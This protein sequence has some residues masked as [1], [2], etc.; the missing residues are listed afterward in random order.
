M[1]QFLGDRGKNLTSAGRRALVPRLAGS[2]REAWVRRPASGSLVTVWA[3]LSQRI[4]WMRISFVLC[5][6]VPTLLTALY[7]MLIAPREYTTE[8]KFAVRSAES[9]PYMSASGRTK[10]SG[11]GNIMSA[12]RD[13]SQ[14]QEPF[15]VANYIR[16]RTIIE[17][18]GGRALLYEIYSRP[19]IGGWSRLE[20]PV[21]L[22][23]AWTY[24]NGKVRATIDT[25]SGIIT[26]GVR[27][28][29]A[30]DSLRL[31][32]LIV[33]RSERLVNEMSDRM[34]GDAMERAQAEVEAA[35][36]APGPGAAGPA[37][38]SQPREPA[39]SDAERHL[40]QRQHHGPD[41][42]AHLDSKISRRRCVAS[43]PL[44]SPTMRVLTAQVAAIEKQIDGLKEKLTSRT[45]K[46]ALSA[47]IGDYEAFSS[48]CSLR[49][50]STRS[51]SRATSM[52]GPNRSASI[53]IWSRW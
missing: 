39:R 49:R 23:E 51:L 45:Q 6:L 1:H 10:S 44:N 4:G 8:A 53:C 25:L 12:G 37:R 17:D 47:Q 48:R 30:D 28:F 3:P 50:S 20:N 41:E 16:G 11:S 36:E 18:V 32:Q 24:W 14:P 31:T 38:I 5:V 19:E 34:R 42:G 7:L 2:L 22:E 9:K 46:G 27:A 33:E 21:S 35:Q 40:A 26:V 29:D 15:I 13:V 52:P 43:S